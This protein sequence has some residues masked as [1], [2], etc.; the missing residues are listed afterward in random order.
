MY[1][2][3]NSTHAIFSHK[4][5]QM[6]FSEMFKKLAKEILKEIRFSKPQLP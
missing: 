3:S 4:T 1:I 6:L 2:R 5:K